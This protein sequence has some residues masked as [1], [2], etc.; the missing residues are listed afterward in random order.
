MQFNLK[1][2]FV[3]L[4][5]VITALAV[6]AAPATPG[7]HT[8]LEKRTDGNVYLCTDANFAGDC[9]NYGFFDSQCSNLPGEFSD[10]ISSFG[11][12]AGWLCT[13]NINCTGATYAGVSPGFALLPDWLNDTFSSVRCQRI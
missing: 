3:A 1:L 12:D 5:A 6:S 4:A 8:A 10:D 9:T 11:P 13:I 7:G 2:N